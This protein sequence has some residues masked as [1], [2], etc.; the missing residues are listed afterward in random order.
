MAWT[1]IRTAAD[2]D[3]PRLQRT[4]RDPPRRRVYGSG[5]RLSLFGGNSGEVGRRVR[6]RH[7]ILAKMDY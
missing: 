1:T 3:L 5:S 2:L 4:G 6:N 7:D